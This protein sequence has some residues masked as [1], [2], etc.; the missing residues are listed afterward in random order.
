[1]YMLLAPVFSE[2]YV[3][4]NFE[5]VPPVEKSDLKQ[6]LF[7]IEIFIEIWAKEKIT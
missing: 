4:P 1:M 3:S 2:L 6:D 7:K 5:N